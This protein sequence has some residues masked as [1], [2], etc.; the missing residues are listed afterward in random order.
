MIINPPASYSLALTLACRRAVQEFEALPRD[1][2]IE[3][4]RIEPSLSRGQN[5]HDICVGRK[6]AGEHG[7]PASSL[8]FLFESMLACI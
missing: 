5:N 2:A 3:L 4:G 7:K 1:L 6:L 8:M